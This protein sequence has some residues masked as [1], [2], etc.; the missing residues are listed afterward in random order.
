MSRG[1]RSVPE[2]TAELERR[3]L[4]RLMT[5]WVDLNWSLFGDAM[6]PASLLLLDGHG[7]LGQ[8]SACDRTIGLSRAAVLERPWLDTIETLKH[9]MAHQFVDEVLG[10]EPEPHGP[11]FRRVCALRGI[12]PAATAGPA[13][14]VATTKQDRIIDRVRKLLALAESSNQHEAELAASTAQRLIL[15]FNVDLDA[16]SGAGEQVYGYAHLGEPT[17]RLQAHQRQLA[18]LLIEH[19]FVQA[20]WVSTYRPLEDKAGTVLEICGRPENLQM[21]EFVHDFVLRTVERLWKEHKKA[22]GIRSD[23]DRRSFMAGAVAGF[24]AKLRAKRAEAQREGLVWVGE[25][26]VETY[27]RRRHPRTRSSRGTGRGRAEAYAQG[28][29]AGR[30]IVLSRPMTSGPGAG[31]SPRALRGGRH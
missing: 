12:D 20:I 23:R 19:F 2:L 9:E 5:E 11:K 6:R 13:Q 25:A 10:G 27:M 31:G 26:G 15:K 18:S 7:R 24:S 14:G 22:K 16:R 21:A 28:Q 29:S 8:W 4:L 17:G 30:T 1:N 3:L